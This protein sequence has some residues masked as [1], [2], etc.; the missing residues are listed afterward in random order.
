MTIKKSISILI[1]LACLG[2]GFIYFIATKGE[3]EVYTTVFAQ[4]GDILQ[5]VSETGTVKAVNEL[6]L[7]FL[8]TGKLEKVYYGVGD[9]VKEGVVIAE[10]DYSALA[11]N[12]EEAQANLDVARANL[13]KLLAG[14]TREEVLLA[15]AGTNQAKIAYEVAKKELETVKNKVEENIAQTKKTYSDLV[16]K[17]DDDITTYEQAVTSAQTSLGNT[18]SAYQKT[19][20]N[21][22]ESALTIVEDKI[23]IANT[24]LDISDRTIND[25]DGEDEIG[26]KKPIYI[27]NTKNTYS[28]GLALL[29]IANSVLVLAKLNNSDEN[30]GDLI[31]KTLN[32]LN[33]T[34]ESLQN[35]FSALENSV[36]SS[37]FS[38]T[39]I[40]TLKGNITAQQTLVNTAI[41]AVQTAKQN[42]DSAILSYNTNVDAAK[43]VL[44]KAEVSYD[45]AVKN[46][47]NSLFDA[48]L[49][50]VQ[51]VTVAES[52][53]DTALEAW[54]VA[55]AQ[56]AKTKALANK[57]DVTLSQAKVR[58]AEAALN[59]IN[60]QIENSMIKAP[61]DGQITKFDFEVGEQVVSG[62][63][64]VSVLG[65]S[66]FKIEVL[67]SEADIAKV[68]KGDKSTI[69]LDSFGDEIEFMGEVDFIEPAETEVQDVIYY[70]VIVKFDPGESKIKSGMTANV[71]II[72]EEKHDI[73]VVPTRSVIDKNGDGR[74][75]RIL[76]G[77]NLKERKVTTGLRGDEGVIEILSG[78]KEGEEVITHIKKNN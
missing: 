1:I 51:S 78:L 8:N 9:Q 40:D 50:G 66:D 43:S 54:Q 26:I 12:R 31:N 68:N 27:T 5:T 60:N 48:E 35:C 41:S 59:N 61:I 7:S 10:L 55:S 13:N 64:A 57:H 3:K 24:A 44:E 30:V 58:Q 71:V 2:A 74:V 28:E 63:N 42:L 69:T 18:M 34:Y 56:E 16:S 76:E 49:S 39:R 29:D 25:E 19:I 62:A 22:K 36:T 77:K 38:Q 53:V 67:I 14:A 72:T 4:K 37:S 6:N 11:I 52:K 47:R 23:T 45:D 32:L 70:K 75:V 21:Y 33:K 73:L 15:E 20:D 65:E 46:A 17:T